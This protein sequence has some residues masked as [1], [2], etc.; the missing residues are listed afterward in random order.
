MTELLMESKQVF[1][2]LLIASA[3]FR[4]TAKEI[5]ARYRLKCAKNNNFE[6]INRYEESIKEMDQ[7][8]KNNALRLSR[9]ANTELFSIHEI[10]K[11]I[12]YLVSTI[13]GKTY[14]V[15]IIYTEK[16]SIIYLFSC[17]E[18]I[19]NVKNRFANNSKAY[20]NTEIENIVNEDNN[21]KILAIISNKKGLISTSDIIGDKWE[22]VRNYLDYLTNERLKNGNKETLEKNYYD[23]TSDEIETKTYTYCQDMKRTLKK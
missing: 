5:S 16:Q 13:E 20:S 4:N 3:N 21:Y 11:C 18:D 6:E 10:I 9:V 8:V 12:A 2:D 19:I 7:I 1:G 17:K 15:G 22:Y 14:N 23:L